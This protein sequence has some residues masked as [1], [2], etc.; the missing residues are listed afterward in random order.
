MKPAE[1][2]DLDTEDLYLK[3]AETK[4]EVF[5]LRF[6]LATGQ[7]DDYKRLQRA[8]RDVGRIRTVI[9]E[10]EIEAFEEEERRLEQVGASGQADA[11]VENGE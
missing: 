10:R 2:R 11:E 1:L 3:L 5:N 8:K 6:R 7:L 9:R 4:E